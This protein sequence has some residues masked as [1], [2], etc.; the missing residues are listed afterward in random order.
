MNES[1]TA[2]AEPVSAVAVQVRLRRPARLVAA[3]PASAY[4]PAQQRVIDLL[5]RQA[6]EGA[7]IDAGEVTAIAEGMEARLAQAA[8]QIP[9]RTSLWVGKSAL[10][11]FARC[12]G[13]WIADLNS[14]FRWSVPSVRGTVAHKAIELALNWR[15]EAEPARMVDAAIE[16]LVDHG[17]SAGTYLRT[18][19]T[20][21]RA[22]LRSVS[23]QMVTSFEECFPPLRS[24]WRPVL[25]G[26]VRAEFGS[27][28]VVLAG[29]PDLTLGRATAGGKVI[30]DFKT[31]SRSAVHAQ[32]LRFYALVDALR[33]GL[34]PRR[35][36]TVYLDSGRPVAETVTAEVLQSAAN[37]VVTSVEA[38]IAMRW[39]TAPRQLRSGGHCAWCPA[40]STCVA[41]IDL[42]GS[43]SADDLEW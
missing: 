27:G 13:G 8:E 31:G 14:P 24:R 38:M 29:K 15:G 28:R 20:V 3:N 42:L 19:T 30:I 36:A 21:E 26:S 4:S 18:L 16:H 22:E 35:V 11:T 7:V 5:G 17:G 2:V 9:G 23:V 1:S 32:D 39:G 34:A 40:R 43:S 25:E 6:E 37:R 33:L 12:P 10:N 41:G